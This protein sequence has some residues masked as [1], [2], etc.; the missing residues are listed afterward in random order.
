MGALLAF[1]GV[2]VN[3]WF[4]P[5]SMETLPGGLRVMIAGTAKVVVF[6]AVPL[7]QPPSLA[8]TAHRTAT[9]QPN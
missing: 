5:N 7:L 9:A 8:I 3:C 6:T 2:A 1:S 4:V